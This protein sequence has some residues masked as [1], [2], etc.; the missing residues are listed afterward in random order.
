[1]SVRLISLAAIIVLT[2][3]G[4]GSD[5]DTH[6][7]ED[8]LVDVDRSQ[9]MIF[10]PAQN[11]NDFLW[12]GAVASFQVEGEFPYFITDVDGNERI[13]RDAFGKQVYQYGKS[14][15][16]WSNF[17]Q[18][19]I[20]GGFNMTYGQRAYRAIDQYHLYEE[21]FDL[22]HDMGINSYRFS[23]AWTRIVPNDG[24]ELIPAQLEIMA[25][26]PSR[27]DYEAADAGGYLTAMTQPFRDSDA[28]ISFDG[29]FLRHASGYY[30]DLA[31]Q[32]DAITG[33]LIYSD[34]GDFQMTLAM[35]NGTPVNVINGM[36]ASLPVTVSDGMG[37]SQTIE[38]RMVASEK[39]PQGLTFILPPGWY[40]LNYHG[41]K[42]YADVIAALKAR[43]ME[44]IVTMYHW[45]T[46][47]ELWYYTF[48]AWGDRI[49]LDYF[50]NYAEILLTEYG[51]DVPYWLTVNEPFSDSCVGDGIIGGVVTGKYAIDFISTFMEKV[52]FNIAI[53]SNCT[54]YMHNIYTGHARITKMFNDMQAGAYTSEQTGNAI[55]VASDAKLGIVI[56]ASPADPATPDLEDKKG[57]EMYDRVW[58]T[59]WLTPFTFKDGV[60]AHSDFD[61]MPFVVEADYQYDSWAVEYMTEYGG[62][63][64]YD[65]CMA[66]LG[67]PWT[68]RFTLQMSTYVEDLKLMAEVGIN[69]IGVNYYTRPQISM[70]PEE[71]QNRTPG[72]SWFNASLFSR[73]LAIDRSNGETLG[74]SAN[75]T[76]DPMG[77]YEGLTKVSYE[78]PNADIIISE[79]G[80]SYHKEWDGT[81]QEAIT[82]ENT[83]DDYFRIR[84]LEGMTEA[85][86]KAKEVDGIN[87]TGVMPWSTFDNFEWT[88]GELNRFGIV[89]IDYDSPNLDRHIK[90]SG[91][92]YKELIENQGL[93]A[94]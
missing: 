55:T 41:I 1:M 75:G 19:G 18:A 35:V 44:P 10:T 89:F 8:R 46:P 31:T 26:L 68:C 47:T 92:W 93:L 9:D 15:S 2:F 86:W 51:Q 20:D 83:I 13:K 48:R 16:K 58:E 40:P 77:L 21:D 28:L 25:N 84:F 88:S 53:L 7:T 43:N 32:L 36:T 5:D 91:Y 24:A 60:Y 49:T 30:A 22:M 85:I 90:A 12:G 56:G 81:N 94:D 57:A 64:L 38:L 52:G 78:F 71:Q 11:G 14:A 54:V 69:F 59:M 29:S 62:Y 50:T 42:H 82:D 61:D 74:L 39:H 27:A 67:D 87:I 79:Y 34:E 66:D 76:Y 63:L 65:D 3:V 73:E 70:V 33:T 80:A 23:I 37:G 6:L 17:T 72:D 45:D 4:C